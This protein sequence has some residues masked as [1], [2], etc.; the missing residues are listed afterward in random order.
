MHKIIKYLMFVVEKTYPVNDHMF[1]T[2]IENTRMQGAK[3]VQSLS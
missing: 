3:Y 1:K 2:D